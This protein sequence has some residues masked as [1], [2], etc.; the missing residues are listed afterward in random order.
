M[1]V[2]SHY[3]SDK[4][5][6]NNMTETGQTGNFVYTYHGVC[7]DSNL[8][9]TTYFFGTLRNNNNSITTIDL[10]SDIQCI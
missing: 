4:V 2:L 1:K 8:T 10:K 7:V 6:Q 3:T 5:L 9:Y